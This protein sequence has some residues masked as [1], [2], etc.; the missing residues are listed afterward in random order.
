MS[1]DIRKDISLEEIYARAKQEKNAKVRSRLL[2]LAAII[3]GKTRTYAAQLAGITLTN[4]RRWV[5]GFNEKGFEGLKAKKQMGRPSLWTS[6]VEQFLKEKALR[7]AKF[8]NDKRVTYRLE[9]FQVMLQEEFGI[10][11]GISTLWYALKRLGLSWVSV[12]QQHPKTNPLSQEEF[13]KKP[14]TRLG[15]YKRSIQQK[16]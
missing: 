15:R 7:G 6:E 2:A 11:Y 12:R 8:E 13:K 4:L 1:I 14:P 9:D 10:H 3:E 5:C 16:K